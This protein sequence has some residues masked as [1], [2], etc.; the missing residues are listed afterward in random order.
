MT[1]EPNVTNDCDGTSTCRAIYR[2]PNEILVELFRAVQE[3]ITSSKSACGVESRQWYRL[4][5]VCKRWSVVARSSAVLWRVIQLTGTPDIRLL[6]YSLTYSGDMPVDISCTYFDAPFT[7]LTPLIAPH[8]HRIR[9]LKLDELNIIG[10][11]ALVSLLYHDMPQLEELLLSFSLDGYDGEDEE[12]DPLDPDQDEDEDGNPVRF[13]FFWF[14]KDT[15]FPRIVH[16]HIGRSVA[17]PLRFPVLP[18]LRQLELLRC[19]VLGD[20]S[21]VDFVGYL[22]QHPVLEELSMSGLKLSLVDGAVLRLPV[23]LRKFT[24]EDFPLRVSAFLSKLAPLPVDLDV[25]LNRRLRYLEGTD[26]ETPSTAMYSLPEDKSVL[27]I[28]TLVV[29]ITVRQRSWDSYCIIGRTPAGATVEIAA[30]LPEDLLEPLDFLGDLRNAFGNAPVTELRIE[31]HE[32]NKLTEAQWK[33]TLLAFPQLRKIA[34]TDTSTE[35]GSDASISLMKAL[36]SL[37]TISDDKPICSHLKEL[38]LA[39]MGAT[40]DEQLVKEISETLTFRRSLGTPLESLLVYLKT[41]WRTKTASAKYFEKR[42]ALYTSVIH[43]L[44]DVLLLERAPRQAV[45]VV[46]ESDSSGSDGTDNSGS[47]S[48]DSEPESTDSDSESDEESS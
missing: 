23:T 26:P 16:L 11:Q 43:P 29:T 13:P 46:E 28:L 44:I 38:E 22:A 35:K 30:D 47:N 19:T 36:R 32:D 27:P 2:L 14:P 21:S 4:L 10:D 20:V 31:G 34:V 5:R 40:R 18:S 8:A 45:V 1:P 7:A 33:R 9:S 42:E 37:S 39:A 48:E 3:S 12:L 24:L 17:F 41:T 6:K 25:C 15:Q